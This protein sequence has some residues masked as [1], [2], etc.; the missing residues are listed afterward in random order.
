MEKYNKFGY[1]IFVRLGSKRLPG[2][3][4]RKINNKPIL[5][6]I[7]E[8]VK[9][10]KPNY[11]I[12]IATTSL[13]RDKQIVNYCKKRTEKRNQA[14]VFLHLYSYFPL[15]CFNNAINSFHS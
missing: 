4:L 15:N 11:K 10:I 13:K 6:Y 3:A 9:K 12:I 14:K 5:G 2:K 1:I 7:I 8:R